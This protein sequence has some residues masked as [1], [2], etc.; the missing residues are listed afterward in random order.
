MLPG[1]A[2][3]LAPLT[4][5]L[6]VQVTPISLLVSGL[7][8]VVSVVAGVLVAVAFTAVVDLTWWS[9]GLAVLTALVLARVLRLGDQAL[10]APISAMLILGV[11]GAAVAWET[12]LLSTL[13]GTAVGIGLGLIAPPSVP[14]RPAV[15]AV[16]PAKRDV[17]LTAEPDAA[18]AAVAC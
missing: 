17:L 5:L 15:A 16:R 4:A 8:R 9:L 7:D 10:E 2:P 3:V 6:V 18:V 14:V 12:R 1:A 11:D 13:V